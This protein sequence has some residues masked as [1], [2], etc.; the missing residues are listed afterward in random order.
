MKKTPVKITGFPAGREKRVL[1]LYLISLIVNF[2][3]L[4]LYCPFSSDPL[5]GLGTGAPMG[6]SLFRFSL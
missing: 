3:G 5:T 1:A 6:P 4:T 2:L